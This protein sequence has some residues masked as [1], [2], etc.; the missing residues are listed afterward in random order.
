MKRIL[1]LIIFCLTTQF[2]QGQKLTEL[3]K[4]VNSSVVIIK[5][6]SKSSAGSG[7]KV[8]VKSEGG[9]GSG[10][11][12]SEEGLIWTASHVVHTAEKI[13]VKFTDGE[14][15][16]A[17]VLSSD[18]LADVAL[19]KIIG[20]FDVGD[21]HVAEIGDSDKVE[22]GSD[23]FLIGAPLGIE[24][25][26]SK[27]II[28][29]RMTSE[30]MGGHF[31][32]VEYLQTDAS[33]NPGNSGGPFFSMKG[34]VIGIASFILS[35][36]GGFEG[37]GFGATSNVAKKLL[38]ETNNVWSGMEFVYL[39]S[40]LS[41]I[42]NLPQSGGFLVVSVSSKGSGAEA[43]LQGGYINAVIEGTSILLGG[44]VILEVA[45]IKMTNPAAALEAREKMAQLPVGETF[46]IKYFRAGETK[47]KIITI[48]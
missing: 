4:K 45:G 3:Y 1:V 19:I 29:G 21:R 30:G 23:V 36:S 34:E 8:K 41:E 38:M 39:N 37:I 27:G 11:L 15:Y 33:I 44:D 28:S 9:Q 5:T 22:I 43:G 32:P 40:T 18:Q 25:T 46:F 20:N 6:I 48:K 10:V 16:E 42:F 2:S 17:E 14:V 12:I 13:A 35:E 31:L 26:V 7:D 47:L 24:Q